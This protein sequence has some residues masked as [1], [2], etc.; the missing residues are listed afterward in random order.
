M[1]ARVLPPIDPLTGQHPVPPDRAFI[2]CTCGGPAWRIAEGVDEWECAA[3]VG[4]HGPHAPRQVAD[5]TGM[6][7][8]AYGPFRL[9]DVGPRS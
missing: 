7:Q 1:K 3:P 8:I 9:R 2:R 6:P 4:P 5:A